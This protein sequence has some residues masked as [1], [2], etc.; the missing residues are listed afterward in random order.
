MTG[1]PC[2]LP[3]L[4]DA[5]HG[6]DSD[7]HFLGYSLDGQAGFPQPKHL[8]PVEDTL[9]PTDGVAAL[10]AM[11][12]GIFHSRYHPLADDVS[13]Q[14]RHGGDNCEHGLAHRRGC[15]QGLLAGN[16]VDAERPEFGQGEHE[17]LDGSG[18]PI[19]SP[20]QHDLKLAP[21]GVLHEALQAGTV[22][23][24]TAH[25]VGINP[26]EV[27]APL[28]QHLAERDLLD[29]GILFEA[30]SLASSVGRAYTE[31]YGGAFGV[32]VRH[33][34]IITCSDP[35]IEGLSLPPRRA[36]ARRTLLLATTQPS[37]GRL[38]APFEVE[39]REQFT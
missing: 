4:Y 13:L 38:R 39:E 28:L 2:A 32:P 23:F 3:I 15:V 6:A 37:P 17:L 29:L 25:S 34:T 5:D 36:R 18:E 22:L 8:T 9:W 30:I 21:L 19:K 35:R 12:A 10:C 33:A 31:V 20:D 7:V 24:G 1:V 16:E 26:G 27:P 11:P 14:L